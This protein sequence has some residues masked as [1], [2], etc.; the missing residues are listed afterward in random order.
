MYFPRGF[1]KERAVE[2]GRL[3]QQSYSQ[4]EA[5]RN[6]ERWEPVGGYSLVKELLYTPRQG[7]FLKNRSSFDFEVE[8]LP[9]FAARQLKDLPIGFVARRGSDFFLVFRGTVTVEEWIRNLNISLAPFLRDGFGRVHEGFLQAYTLIRSVVLEALGAGGG[10]KR[11]FI[12]GHSLGGALATMA[13]ADVSRGTMYP[14]PVLYTFGSPRV[15]DR[16]FADAFNRRNGLASYRI[17]NTSDVVVSIPLPV[18]LAGF[19]GGFFTHVETPVDF[20]SQE[21]SLEKN[22]DMDTYLAP[23]GGQRL[24]G[25]VAFLQSVLGRR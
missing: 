20:T 11:L 24:P 14:L 12:T 19:L 21:E 5:F 4:L 2:L 23:L 1:D 7:S 16:Y 15:G 13:A 22:H 18:P 3:V 17:V 9:R 25:P 8:R 6:D 10:G